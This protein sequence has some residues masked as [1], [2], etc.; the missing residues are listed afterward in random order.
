M[1]PQ[2]YESADAWVSR[3]WDYSNYDAVRAHVFY[4]AFTLCNAAAV[5]R[6]QQGGRVAAFGAAAVF[7][8]DALQRP[9]N[10]AA[11]DL[12]FD[13]LRPVRIVQTVHH[14][15]D[16]LQSVFFV[17]HPP[18]GCLSRGAPCGCFR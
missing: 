6:G 5:W 11:C 12:L 8:G 16:A 15:F 18:V 17:V 7:D 1:V 3:L 9:G 13:W 2:H 14:M 10:T 4:M